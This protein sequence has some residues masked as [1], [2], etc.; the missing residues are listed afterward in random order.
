MHEIKE[1]IDNVYKMISS[2]PVT[3]DHID[4]L[5]AARSKLRKIY[6]GLTKIEVEAATGKKEEPTE[7]V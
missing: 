4:T 5:A 3:G 2:V 6:A 7:E 1:E